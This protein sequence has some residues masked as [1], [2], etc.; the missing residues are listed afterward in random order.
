MQACTTHVE[1]LLDAYIHRWERVNDAWK[2]TGCVQ[3]VRIVVSSPAA[4][5]AMPP[6]PVDIYDGSLQLGTATSDCIVGLPFQASGAVRLWLQLVTGDV[7]EFTG[8]AVRIE[9]T[10]PAQYIEDLPLEFLPP[11]LADERW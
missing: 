1:L 11:C 9:G 2:G 3:H 5:P 8:S 4:G 7:V 6:L 10:G